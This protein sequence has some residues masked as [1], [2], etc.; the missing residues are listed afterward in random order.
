MAVC[1]KPGQQREKPRH[2]SCPHR[3][4]KRKGK[5]KGG[6]TA[7]AARKS[8]PNAHKRRRKTAYPLAASYARAATKDVPCRKKKCPA[9]V[10]GSGTLVVEKSERG[11]SNARPPRPE[12][13]ALPTALLSVFRFL[14]FQRNPC[15]FS[16]AAS[17]RKTAQSLPR[18]AASVCDIRGSKS[19]K[20]RIRT[21]ETL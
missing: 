10:S 4:F 17:L 16:P 6:K 14:D 3:H 20:D 8:P 2:E 18:P 13:G 21:Y 11:D 5:T 7:P 19:G 9:S 15:F 1:G 12:R